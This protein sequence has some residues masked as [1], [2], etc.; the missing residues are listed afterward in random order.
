M[1]KRPHV[2]IVG[3]GFGGLYAAMGLR[4]APVDVTVVDRCNHHLFQPLLYEVA[5]AALAAP[6]VATPIRKILRRQTN[7]RV[8]MA[9]VESI[10]VASRTVH[11]VDGELAFDYLV[12][13]T[14]VTHSYFGNDSWAEHAPGLKTLGDAHEIRRRILLAYERAE[15]EPD[16]EE[17]RPWLR[18]V[19]IGGGPT[20]V[21]LA[22]A[23]ADIAQRTLARDFQRFD[24]RDAEV[25]LLEGG[26]RILPSYPPAL[27]EDAV[28]QLERLG[29]R[30]RTGAT[31]TNVDALGVDVGDERIDA[32]TVV[33]AAGV[34][35]S[36]LTATLPVERDRAGR[37]KVAPDLSLPGHPEV[38]VIGDA[39]HVVQDGKPVPGVAPAAIQMGE[40]VARNLVATV[41][42]GA[43]EP[44]RYRDKG[45]LATIGRASAVASIA[46]MRFSGFFAWLMWL[47]VH[48]FF[49]I[50]FRNRFIVM[51]EWAW[52]YITYQ[53]SARVILDSK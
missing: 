47:L 10:D 22:G 27:S 18:F 36:P 23:M 21:E 14:G 48:I 13:A 5:T 4:S 32:R 46:G 25:M 15:R 16:A 40:H 50:G 20:G 24:P 30:V 9:T 38:F 2:V 41:A 51:F 11:L 31:V 44:F 34:Q 3:G 8:L 42:G 33:W 49:L 7:T 17:R 37:V 6:D 39:A 52:L 28:A 19:I 12:V 53:R 45:S 43:R 26:E 29:A 35:A 1:S